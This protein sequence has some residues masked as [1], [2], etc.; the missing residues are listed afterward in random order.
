[1]LVRIACDGLSI[2]EY[3]AKKFNHMVDVLWNEVAYRR[4]MQGD[5][6][7]FIFTL[8]PSPSREG[9]FFVLGVNQASRKGVVTSR[10]VGCG[11]AIVRMPVMWRSA[12]RAMKPSARRQTPFQP[13]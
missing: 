8:P 10:S 11:L 3:G 12:A 4:G 13:Q 2:P 6:Q 7:T 5:L 9:S 1:M